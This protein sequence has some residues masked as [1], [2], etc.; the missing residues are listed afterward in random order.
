MNTGK[1]R[2]LLAGLMIM[3]II[4][5][6]QADTLVHKL[7]SLEKKTDTVKQVNNTNPAGYNE[8]TKI[9]FP[10]YFTLLFDDLKQQL[11]APFRGTQQD[12]KRFAALAAGTAVLSFADKP[13]QESMLKLR[14]SSQTLRD[15][16]RYI[17][18]VGG[19]SEIYTLA[20]LGIYGFVFKNEKVRTTTLLASQS[21]ISAAVIETSLKYLTSR[22]R[23]SY[24]DPATG[25]RRGRFHGPFYGSSNDFRSFPS[26][27]ATAAFAAATVYAMEYRKSVWVPIV[28]YT[29]ATLIALSRLTENV[30]WSTDILLGA[31][32]GY[33]CGRQ[34]VNNYHRYA[35]IK[36]GQKKA[37]MS[38]N[39]QYN[40]HTIQPGLVYKF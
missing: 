30:H 32:L 6:A 20:A 29:S 1:W 27:H 9:T 16:S 3:P 7:D 28:A 21:Y 40:N 33:L 19:T 13:I 2:C 31:T 15:V 14:D 25:E 4:S 24:I 17:T 26:G 11:T 12:W 39:L 23:P 5:F 22:Q 18:N 34:V 38:F 37:T 35:K 8:N 10:V 36:S